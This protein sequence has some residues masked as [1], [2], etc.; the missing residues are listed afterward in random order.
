MDSRH[1]QSF[2]RWMFV[3]LAVTAAG[4]SGIYVGKMTLLGGSAQFLF[5]VC[6][7]GGLAL[8]TAYGAIRAP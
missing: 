5:P 1:N 3:V 6:G 7:F 4:A 8:A 2:P